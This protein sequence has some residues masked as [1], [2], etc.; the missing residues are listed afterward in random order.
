MP[1][2]SGF[3]DKHC[4]L[5]S[6]QVGADGSHLHNRL[7]VPLGR[8]ACIFNRELFAFSLSRKVQFWIE[9]LNGTLEIAPSHSSTLPN[10]KELP[11]W[12]WLTWSR[13]LQRY[14][15]RVAWFLLH[16]TL[17]FGDWLKFLGT[18]PDQKDQWEM[19]PLNPSFYPIP[20]FACALRPNSC[21]IPPHELSSSRV[22]LCWFAKL[23]LPLLIDPAPHFLL[24]PLTL[25]KQT[26]SPSW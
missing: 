26:L 14:H 8:L 18:E 1:L 2:Y 23:Q 4:W 20:Q 24:F 16:S 3:T 15:S 10:R 17:P 19:A 7:C 6:K 22:L 12:Y 5:L 9:R 13:T 25:S 11:G 21:R